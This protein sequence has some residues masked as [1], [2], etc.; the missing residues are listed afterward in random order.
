MK[1]TVCSSIKMN[2]LLPGTLE[3]GATRK[4]SALNKSKC[5]FF[6]V[7]GP[8]GSQFNTVLVTSRTERLSSMTSDL[9]TLP[10]FILLSQTNMQKTGTFFQGDFPWRSSSHEQD[11]EKNLK[12]HWSCRRGGSRILPMWRRKKK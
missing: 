1:I 10:Q 11:G 2:W 4:K 9:F 3:S 7:S 6:K 5:I 8:M 12:K